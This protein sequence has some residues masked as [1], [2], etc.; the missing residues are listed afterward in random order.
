L[1]VLNDA[2]HARYLIYYYAL[3]FTFLLFLQPL[4]L[5]G[6]RSQLTNISDRKQTEIQLKHIN[7]ELLRA[8]KLK[9]EFLANMSHEL[10]TPLNSIL[11]LSNALG[12]KLLGSLNEKQLKAIGTVESS[13]EHL[14]SLINDILDLSKISSGMMELDIAPISVKNLCDSSLVFVKQQAFQKQVQIDSKI[15]PLM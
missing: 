3:F 12:E 14:L 4:F 13:G 5:N 15:P 6:A 10:R 1:G 11:G 7:E 2:F 8:T 9:D